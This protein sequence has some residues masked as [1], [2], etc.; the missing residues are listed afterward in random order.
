M[1]EIKPKSNTLS[2][3]GWGKLLKHMRTTAGISQNK[4]AE[5]CG[6]KQTFVSR[7]EKGEHFLR[8]D[9]IQEW[10]QLCGYELIVKRKSPN[11]M[12]LYET[13]EIGCDKEEMQ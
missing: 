6:T 2:S 7:N 4:M 1:A 9:A 13:I 3:K 8:I 10:A 12:G 5:L 11:E